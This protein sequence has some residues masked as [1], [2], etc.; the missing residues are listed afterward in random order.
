MSAFLDSNI[1]VYAFGADVRSAVAYGLVED[2]GVIS[3]QSL[4]EMAN[5][6]RRKYRWTW[7]EVRRATRDVI[8]NCPTIVMLDVELHHLGL[9]LAERY[10]LS[11]YDG[12][13][14]A[15][16]VV[17]GCDTL[18]SEDMHHGLVIDGRVRI[19]NPFAPA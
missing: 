14:A 7:N 15:A 9:R 10:T 17:A 13:I 8:V 3:A 16:A 4:N 1:L 19:V 6:L 18:Y 2:G 12:M 5:V 11:V